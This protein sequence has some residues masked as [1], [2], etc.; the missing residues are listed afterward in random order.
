M[1]LQNSVK[2]KFSIIYTTQIC[3]LKVI[4]LKK[5]NFAAKREKFAEKNRNKTSKDIQLYEKL[6]ILNYR[7]NKGYFFFLEK[8]IFF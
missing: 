4:L 3:F 8:R 2:A 1:H 5:I 6:N 7:Y